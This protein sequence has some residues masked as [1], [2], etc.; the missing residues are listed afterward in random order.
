MFQYYVFTVY[1]CKQS[2][3][4]EQLTWSKV[5][6]KSIK[7]PM[8]GFSFNDSFRSFSSWSWGER[9][10]VVEGTAT[11]WRSRRWEE[12][13]KIR[14]WS[15]ITTQTEHEA[16]DR[17]NLKRN[18]FKGLVSLRRPKDMKSWHHYSSK[19]VWYDKLW[20]KAQ[21]NWQASD[22]SYLIK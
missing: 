9:G 17:M 2:A 22:K 18:F 1:H 16:N 13:G 11:V 15:S 21:E 6:H 3:L 19:P 12:M 7:S 10:A 4:N 8:G 5:L 14:R 20:N